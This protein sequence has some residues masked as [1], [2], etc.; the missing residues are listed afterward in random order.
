MWV[1]FDLD[2]TL[3]QSEEGI[4][5]CARHALKAMGWPEPDAATLRKFIGPPLMWSFQNLA[6]MNEEQALEA[7]KIYRERYNTI[8]LFENRVYPGVRTMLRTLKKAGAHLGV[9][10][11]KPEGPTIRILEH[12]GILPLLET[13]HCAT[14][15]SADKEQMIRT[16]LPEE[17]GEAWMIG[18]RKFDMEGGKRAGIH[19]LGVTYGYGS[20][21]ELREAGAEALAKTPREILTILC[22]ETEIAPGA[23]L[24]MEGLD[25]SGKGT[26]MDRLE[27]TLDRYGFEVIRTREPG[28]TPIGE[29]IRRILLDRENAEMTD[30]TEALL[31][32]AARAQLVR[33]VIRPAVKAGKILLCDRFLDSSAAYQGGGRQ[34]GVEKILKINEIAVDGTLPDL[35][36]YLDINHRKALE[37]RCAASEPDRLEMEAE[38][39]HARVEEGYHQLIA[40]HPERFAVVNAEGDREEIAAEIARK[41]LEKLL[42]EKD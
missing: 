25:G 19:T 27:N 3:T 31:Y 1:L 24:S 29:K 18:D 40:K 10:T 5:N 14:D 38:N 32:A 4:W 36:V 34:M 35:T 15:K 7:Q 2:G 30:E 16:A 21:E 20:E 37:R 8:G 39:F 42:E 23:F 17:H 12:F 41:V 6:G 13:V 26:Q 22:P 28:G 9:V 11:G 33:E